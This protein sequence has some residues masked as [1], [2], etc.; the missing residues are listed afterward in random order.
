MFPLHT[1]I[2]SEGV[3]VRNPYTCDNCVFN[4]TQYHE[5]GTQIGFCLQ[6]N[7]L[8]MNSLHTTCHFLRRKDL[9]FFLAIEG[10]REH[11]ERFS[12]DQGIVFYYARHKEEFRRYSEY[13]V[14]L[15]NTYDPY[16]H[17][18]ALYHK[19]QKK[20]TFIQAFAASRNPI[21]SI[22][23]SCLTRRYVLNCGNQRDNYRLVLSVVNDLKEN[24]NIHPGD[25]RWEVS[26]QEFTDLCEHYL[27]EL[28]LL[29]L[30]AVQEYGALMNDE[31]V[32]WISDE[33][34]GSLFASWKEFF[35]GVAYLAPI[36]IRYIID[37]ADSRH[38]FF[39]RRDETD[40]E[41]DD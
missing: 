12:E 4:P 11:A 15:T 5:L 35:A 38:Q 39:P 23:S 19:T 10:E 1:T 14:W 3:I 40:M 8:L 20:W 41:E 25:F 16:L 31:R 32:M 6:Y 18:A 13:H 24:P 26:P 28:K 2:L 22:M 30:Y 7:C 33:L 21:K 9:P 37:S 34:N 29:Q 17:E 27:K 36:A